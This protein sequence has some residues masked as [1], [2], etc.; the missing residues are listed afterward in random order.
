MFG[1]RVVGAQRQRPLVAGQRRAGVAGFLQRRAAR[2]PGVGLAGR[3]LE[4]AVVGID[5]LVQ[6]RHAL[7]RI[8]EGE[9]G[10]RIA[11]PRRQRLARAGHGVGVAAQVVQGDRA[12]APGFGKRG[13]DAQRARVAVQ[14]LVQ[15]AQAPQRIAAVVPGQR[16]VRIQAQR[17]LVAVQ[18]RAGAAQVL[19][20][21][22]Q[23]AVRARLLRVD[24]Q[25]VRDQAR[26]QRRIAALA[27]DHAQQVQGVELARRG[28]Q[29]LPVQ[30]LGR[31]QP[32]LPV[33]LHGLLQQRVRVRAHRD[34]LQ[35]RSVFDSGSSRTRCPVA[36]KIAL[37]TAGASGGNA[38]SPRPVT[39]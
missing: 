31:V 33:Q 38:G 11:R 29:H 13:L 22:A 2:A 19:Q 18:R 6:P 37:H 21:G 23:V 12:V 8:A 26:R 28:L 14:R 20:R 9:Q 17:R 5:G 3:G 7:Q 36:A 27:L 15:P 10:V 24:G 35:L 16:V 25:R 4:R 34:Q 1:Q 39:G 30:R 32:A